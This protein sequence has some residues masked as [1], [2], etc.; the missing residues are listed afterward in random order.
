[1]SGSVSKFPGK[2]V[3]V[4]EDHYLNQELII[5]I[6]QLMECEVTIAAN[7]DEGVRFALE[8]DFHLILMDI[9]MPVKDGYEATREIRATQRKRIPIIALTACAMPGDRE[10]C[11]EAGMDAY[12][13]K[14][15]DFESLEALLNKYLN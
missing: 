8:G 4:V 6:L 3:L 9:M 10:R 14:P 7:G 13:A 15:L 1:M 11:L 5:G 12:L 2:K